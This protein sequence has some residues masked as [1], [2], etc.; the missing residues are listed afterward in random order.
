MS[1]WLLVSAIPPGCAL[2]IF[3][4]PRPWR[5]EGVA[6]GEPTVPGGERGAVGER[7]GQ[8]GG[9]H[10]AVN[11]RGFNYEKRWYPRGY[12][13]IYNIYSIY[14]YIIFLSSGMAHMSF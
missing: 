9:D 7:G 3:G 4:L 14:I 12:V 11:S 5:P 2:R 10:P 1:I 6:A 8:A 13:Y